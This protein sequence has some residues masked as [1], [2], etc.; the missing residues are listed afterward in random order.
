MQSDRLYIYEQTQ[1]INRKS[2]TLLD[3]ASINVKQ[4]V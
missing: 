4:E 3:D 2:Q 1:R